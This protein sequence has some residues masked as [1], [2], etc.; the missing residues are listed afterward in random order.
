MRRKGEVTALSGIDSGKLRLSAG[1]SPICRSTLIG[2][3][4]G[5]RNQEWEFE[6]LLRYMREFIED[7]LVSL[8]LA[9]LLLGIW[10]LTWI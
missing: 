6:S 5:L 10:V 1:H 9:L 4:A 8:L 7:N 3:E 2:K